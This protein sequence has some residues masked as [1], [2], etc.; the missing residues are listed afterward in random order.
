MDTPSGSV[1]PRGPNRLLAVGVAIAVLAGVAGGTG[2]YLLTRPGAT[3]LATCGGLTGPVSVTSV[4]VSPDPVLPGEPLT[5]TA[6]IEG[7]ASP[8]GEP[9]SVLYELFSAQGVGGG[10]V[11]MCPSGNDTY[12]GLLGPFGNHTTL[13]IFVAASGGSGAW[14][15]SDHLTVP[16]GTVV[17]ASGL[18]VGNFSVT[19]ASP[20][21][22]YPPT[23]SWSLTG[24]E[25]S[26]GVSSYFVNFG[27]PGSGQ[28]GASCG[29]SSGGYA[30][31]GTYSAGYPFCFPPDHLP[32]VGTVP[33]SL[34]LVRIAAFDGTGAI[35]V[36]AVYV[37][38]MS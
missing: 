14:S 5:I 2:L 25:A 30:V 19:P 20:T 29:G 23:V 10:G 15:F 28:G 18:Q 38:T 22:A 13:W 27:P 26:V 36:S 7:P 37:F 31:P 21:A 9:P 35:V 34:W 33:G 4:R 32:E 6:T 16:V 3:P 17:A 8:T 24:H 11:D 12:T 1:P